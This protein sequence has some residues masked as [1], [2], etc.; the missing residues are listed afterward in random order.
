MILTRVVV[1]GARAGEITVALVVSEFPS[2]A[3]VGA[4]TSD[5]TVPVMEMVA[6]PAPVRDDER[7]VLVVVVKLPVLERVDVRAAADEVL[8]TTRPGVTG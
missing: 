1:L 8:E 2:L 3:V 4:A 5:V 7:V 6:N